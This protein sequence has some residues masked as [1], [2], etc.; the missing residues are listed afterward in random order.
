[1][2]TKRKTYFDILRLIA[3]FFVLYQHTDRLAVHHYLVDGGAVSYWIS[4]FLQQFTYINTSVFFL[5]S[6]ALLLHK[7]ESLKEIMKKRVL[8][9][10][11]IIIIFDFIQYCYNY[12]NNPEIGFNIGIIFKRMYATSMITQYWFLYAYLAFI[13]ILPFIRCLVRNMPEYYGRYLILGFIV[14][15]G[16]MP[17]V[18]VLW[19]NDKLLL[20]IPLFTNIIIYPMLGYYLEHVWYEKLVKGL[21]LLWMNIIA[22]LSL[23]LN[24]WYSVA[25]M[26]KGAYYIMAEG[27][28]MIVVITLYLNVKALC[29][30]LA[31]ESNKDSF[32]AK[33]LKVMGKGTF[34]V[35]LLE[36]ELREGFQFIYDKLY[37]SISWLPATFLWLLAA[38]VTGIIISFVFDVIVSG[39]C[40][41]IRK[42]E[43]E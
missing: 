37:L 16:V 30:K 14:I 20:D 3:I 1:M 4:L 27:L 8:K 35:Y 41:L 43:V 36:P 18:E 2:N 19:D 39:V 7:D 38:I 28:N 29:N 9:Y 13:L 21:N 17:L 6:G 10:V 23:C 15:K 11:I 34:V 40:K 12:Y 22:I 33:L 25:F 5:I 31:G 32:L 42:K 24:V 26:E